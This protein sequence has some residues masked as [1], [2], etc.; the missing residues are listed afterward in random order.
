MVREQ[1]VRTLGE[2]GDPVF[3]KGLSNW[4]PKHTV[5][6][7]CV[8]LPGLLST[9][10]LSAGLSTVKVTP[11]PDSLTP[12]LAW[13]PSLSLTHLSL[14][15]S[16]YLPLSLLS[17]PLGAPPSLPFSSSLCSLSWKIGSKR[18]AAVNKGWSLSWTT[19]GLSFYGN[20]KK[21]M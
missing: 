20:R 3:M 1:A 8:S 19:Q 12:H 15:P 4:G 5:V 14:L 11:T 16:T 6:P 17:V 9:Y 21:V 18:A 2:C 10:L 7:L 13:P